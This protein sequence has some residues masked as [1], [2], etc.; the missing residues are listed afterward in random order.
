MITSYLYIVP[1]SQSVPQNNR[2][3]LPNLIGLGFASL[4]LK[5]DALFDVYAA[6]HVVTASSPL[7]EAETKQ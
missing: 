6:K 3:D 7:Y 5:V 4:P 1:L 2:S